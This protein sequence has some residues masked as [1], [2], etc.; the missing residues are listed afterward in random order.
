MVSS[1]N[2]NALTKK[3]R[4]GLKLYIPSSL[5]SALVAATMDYLLNLLHFAS[6][7]G[8]NNSRLN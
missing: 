3:I 8:E 6:C 7:W 5:N 1:L 2:S 4:T